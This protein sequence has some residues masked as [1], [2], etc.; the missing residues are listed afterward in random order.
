[1]PAQLHVIPD[2]TSDDE[3]VSSSTPSD[4]DQLR[5][6]ASPAPSRARPAAT[7]DQPT[8]ASPE[9]EVERA[10][11]AASE[12]HANSASPDAS[13]A[14]SAA[15]AEADEET[16]EHTEPKFYPWP[17]CV[18]EFRSPTKIWG[19]SRDEKILTSVRTMFP[20]A[21]YPNTTPSRPRST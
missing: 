5:S 13:R 16:E 4:V 18:V 1:M 10:T 17:D 21:S 2:T 3:S 8:K 9:V 7:E 6:N 14:N 20:F 11:P 19:L 15:T 12:Y